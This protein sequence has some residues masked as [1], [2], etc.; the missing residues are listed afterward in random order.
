AFLVQAQKQSS[1]LWRT[2]YT[3]ASVIA[4]IAQGFGVSGATTPAP[5][6]AATGTISGTVFNDLNANL[7]R[8][9]EE[10][11]LSAWK[12]YI[13][14]NDNHQF[15]AGEQYTTTDS[16]GNYKLTNVTAGYHIVR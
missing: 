7:K 15:D 1:D 5:T 8:D 11:V 10:G 13:D 16:S 9:T 12:I 4:Y 3:A 2:T 6:P 14:A